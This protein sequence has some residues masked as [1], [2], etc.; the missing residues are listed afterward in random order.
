MAI[1]TWHNSTKDTYGP[2]IGKQFCTATCNSYVYM[3]GNP[4]HVGFYTLD[5]S[6]IQCT[7]ECNN[8]AWVLHVSPY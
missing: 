8:I 7:V 2:H 3:P 4:A 6:Y 1:I 5:I